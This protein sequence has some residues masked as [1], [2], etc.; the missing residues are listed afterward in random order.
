[1]G[2][3]NQNPTILWTVLNAKTGNLEPSCWQA[4]GLQSLFKTMDQWQKAGSSACGF[5]ASTKLYLRSFDNT[6]AQ[7]LGLKTLTPKL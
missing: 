2:C 4:E 1:M 3:P 5:E 6:R 7:G